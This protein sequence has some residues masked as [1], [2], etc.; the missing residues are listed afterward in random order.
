M[1]HVLHRRFSLKIR[2]SICI[3]QKIFPKILFNR[4]CITQTLTD[5]AFLLMWI[6][7]HRMA[8]FNFIVGTEYVWTI[9][10]LINR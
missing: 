9:G 5:L 3:T 1:D 4:S 8:N 10:Y 2:N 7:K 6:C